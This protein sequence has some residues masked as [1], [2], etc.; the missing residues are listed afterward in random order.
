MA[1][2]D[3][4]VSI[5]KSGYDVGMALV[6]L[7]AVTKQALADGLQPTADLPVIVI[8][9]LKDL[10]A[11]MAEMP[12]LQADIAEDKMAFIKGVNLA[13]YELIDALSK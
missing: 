6:K 9:A 2:M 12:N 8:E 5:E 13:V 11:A 7:A 1:K 10:P 3:V 4:T